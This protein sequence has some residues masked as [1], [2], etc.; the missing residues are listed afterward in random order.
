MMPQKIPPGQVCLEGK[1]KLQASGALNQ[2]GPQVEK[3]IHAKK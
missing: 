2:L 1:E 3:G